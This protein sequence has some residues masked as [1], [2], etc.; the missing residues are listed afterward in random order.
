MYAKFHHNSPL[1]SAIFTFF[2]NLEL[3]T[4]STD[5]KC[6]F[7]ISWARFGNPSVWI[8]SMV[9]GMQNFIKIYQK[10][11]GTGPV[12]LFSEFEPR[13][14]LDLSQIS[15]DN[16]IGYILSISMRMQNFITIF[17][18]VLE[19]GTF[20]LFQNLELGKASTDKKCQ[21]TISWAR[22]CQYQCLRKSLSKYSTDDSVILQFLGLDL[23]NIKLSATFYQNIPNGLIVN[24][25]LFQTLN[26]GK[27]STNSK[28]HL[29]ISW[30]TSC[31]YTNVYAK[32]YHNIP[33]S[34]RDRPIFTFSE[35][36]A[37]Q[38]LDR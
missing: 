18:T 6:R 4:A 17:F 37:R 3:G 24:F 30:A 12:S 10:V 20:T 14:N 34:S 28:C 19:I 8:M 21:F 31:Q 11:Q 15:F 38:T 25:H 23:F 2:Q 5:V 32:F 7:V 22:S 35:F 9:M 33:L 36:G 26:L 13:Q 27:T 29:T 1:S 16:L